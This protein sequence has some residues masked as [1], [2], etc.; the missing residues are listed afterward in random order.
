M[1]W[2]YTGAILAI[3]V[4]IVILNLPYIN[5]AESSS[6]GTLGYFMALLVGI[7]ICAMYREYKLLKNEEQKNSLKTSDEKIEKL[8]KI[9]A[10]LETKVEENKNKIK[11]V[12]ENTE[13]EITT[14]NNKI[15]AITGTNI[16]C[17]CYLELFYYF[18]K[19]KEIENV[20]KE[21]KQKEDSQKE[22]KQN[23]D[24]QKLIEEFKNLLNK[25]NL[26]P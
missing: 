26:H 14:L 4:S 12:S 24:S 25:Y 11:D 22:H 9:I 20:Q 16:S 13:K 6:N 18:L 5:L 7:L 1:N 23:A 3:I 17:E 15:S 8:E 21:S 10:S 19:A 2:K